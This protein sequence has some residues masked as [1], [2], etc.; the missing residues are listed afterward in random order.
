MKC[1]PNVK[2]ESTDE[3]ISILHDNMKYELEF[4]FINQ[5]QL[6]QDNFN[7]ICTDSVGNEIF[8]L[9]EYLRNANL[10]KEHASLNISNNIYI[11]I[12]NDHYYEYRKYFSIK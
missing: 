1:S 10:I 8:Y 2:I 4:T 6:L 9:Y 5:R 11:E 7:G 3:C 12:Y